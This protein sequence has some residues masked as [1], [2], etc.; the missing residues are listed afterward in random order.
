MLHALSLFIFVVSM[1]AVGI[2]VW[3]VTKFQESRDS[4]FQARLDADD[5]RARLGREAKAQQ[6]NE[7]IDSK[8]SPTDPT[9]SP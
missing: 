7:P 8:S 2:V 1:I 6:F 4:K 9:P 3:K 5:V